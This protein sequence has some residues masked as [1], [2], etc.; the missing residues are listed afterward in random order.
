MSLR[1][2][3]DKLRSGIPETPALDQ[4]KRDMQAAVQRPPTSNELVAQ[5]EASRRELELAKLLATS[6]SECP[7]CGCR[8]TAR[9]E[10]GKIAIRFVL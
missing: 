7:G 6:E 5:L 1:D 3:I 9:I 2:D 4:L 10:E 8:V